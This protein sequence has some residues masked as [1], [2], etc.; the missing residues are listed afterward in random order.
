M[1]AL[2]PL[3]VAIVSTPKNW[4]GGE[5]QIALLARGLRR[6]GHPV[7]IVA[8]RGGA[9]A[10][11]MR[12]EDFAVSEFTGNGRNPLAVWQIRRHLQRIRPDVL[13]YNDSH[14]LTAAGLAACGLKIPVRIAMRHVSLPIRSPWRFH[15]LAD[16]VIC[17]SNAVAEV[18]REAGLSNDRLRVVFPATDAERIRAGNR[19]AGRS[20]IGIGVCQP[21][22]LV[23]GSLTENKGHRFL[24]DA[25][26]AILRRYP[27]ACLVLT[28]DGPQKEPLQQQA[29][30]LGIAERVRFLGYC[31]NIPDLM[32]GA[33]L[34]VLPSIGGEGLPAVLLDAMFAGT[35]FVAT[36]VG[37]IADITGGDD[38]SSEPLA[39][40]V[41]PRDSSALA[42]AVLH[43]FEHP[44]ECAVRADRAGRRAE[45]YFT[46]DHLVNGMV[47]VYR[48]AMP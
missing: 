31:D 20:S 48:E 24:L 40:I 8:R 25:M 45:Q 13:Q 38:S 22:I 35:P 7:H 19:L 15:R 11:R 12:S 30:Q 46:I 1:N 44:E 23:V 28:S 33:D 17:V 21:M 2:A 29:E 39:W 43:A 27:E 10:Q 6:N 47:E 41:P 26:P 36:A 18:C 14:A 4:Y 42:D 34:F 16:R 32:R 5:E 37:G 9:L 3:S